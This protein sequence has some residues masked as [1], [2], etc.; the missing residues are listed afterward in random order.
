MSL[1]VLGIRSAQFLRAGHSLAFKKSIVFISAPAF[2]LPKVLNYSLPETAHVELSLAV[3]FA[4]SFLSV[5]THCMQIK[6][7][8]FPLRNYVFTRWFLTHTGKWWLL[9]SVF[10]VVFGI[11]PSLNGIKLKRSLVVFSS[12]ANYGWG[13]ICVESARVNFLKVVK[14]TLNLQH[15]YVYN[16]ERS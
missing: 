14:V 15:M 10:V 13:A 6:F 16:G 11:W 7:K 1:R 2:T 8:R 9:S 4:L 12:W 3:S 5:A